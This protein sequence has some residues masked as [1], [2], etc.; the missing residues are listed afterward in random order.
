MIFRRVR[1][2]LRHRDVALLRAQS[3]ALLAHERADASVVE[4]RG[5]GL[6]IVVR[7]LRRRVRDVARLLRKCAERP[8]RRR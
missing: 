7:V 8:A 1:A 5:L 3:G 6:S 2:W 4:G